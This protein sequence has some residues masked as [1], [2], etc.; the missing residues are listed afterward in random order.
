LSHGAACSAL[1]LGAATA[2]A[3]DLAVDTPDPWTALALARAAVAL[4]HHGPGTSGGGSAT[5][6]GETLKA[7][8]WDLDLRADYTNF[9]HFSQ[10]QAEEHAAQSGEFDAIDWSLLTSISAAYGITDDF[11]MGASIGYYHGQ[12]FVGADR[13]DETGVVDS[14]TANPAGLTDLW[15]NAK[16]RVLQGQPGNL[17]LIGGIKLPTGR[18]DVRLSNGELLEP[19]SQPGSG[20]IDFQAGAAYSRFLTSRLTLDASGVYTFR[21]KH[22]GFKVG[23]RF[24]VG[25]ALAYRLTPDINQFAQ[26]S[27]FAEVNGVW[28]QKDEPE[29]GPNP[30]TGG[31]TVFLTPGARV[32]FTEH[33]ALTVA[34]SIPVY[35]DLN[36][37]QDKTRFKFAATLS[38]SF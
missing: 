26:W 30:N 17:S 33:M 22:D 19:S 28:V 31:V 24:D 13:N 21:M 9:Q 3:S 36:G 15:I 6:S 1:L 32:R 18:D 20:A 8:S 2:A 23:D 16:Y 7:G 25:T 10:Q 34:P 11:Q 29:E 5:I 38:F 14:G 12:N 27:V 4:A 35:Q 37:D